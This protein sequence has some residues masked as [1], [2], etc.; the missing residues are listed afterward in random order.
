MH[1]LP[2]R[3]ALDFQKWQLEMVIQRSSQNNPE[4]CGW[5]EWSLESTST[6]SVLLPRG[7]SYAQQNLKGIVGAPPFL[8]A[9]SS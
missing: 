5:K 2:Q 3:G 8:A 1:P 6:H 9:L 4:H 7:A